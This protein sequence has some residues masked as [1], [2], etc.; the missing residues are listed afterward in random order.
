MFCHL[1]DC[2]V[3]PS[4][5]FLKLYTESAFILLQETE[6]MLNKWLSSQNGS[7]K[8]RWESQGQSLL[9]SLSESLTLISEKVSKLATSYDVYAM[10][11]SIVLMWMV[12]FFY[13]SLY[14]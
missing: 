12:S 3:L 1:T 5:N 8:M 6:S 13:L 7:S 4:F 2:N 10:A 14:R 9:T 11:I